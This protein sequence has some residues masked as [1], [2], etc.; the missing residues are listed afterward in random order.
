MERKKKWDLPFKPALDYI[1]AQC[2][3]LRCLKP[4]AYYNT[5]ST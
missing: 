2:F 5:I 1:Q 4:Q 3:G